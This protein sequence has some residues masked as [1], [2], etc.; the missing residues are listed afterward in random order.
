MATAARRSWSGFV[1]ERVQVHPA[2]LSELDLHRR[3]LVIIGG[4]GGIGR[5]IARAAASRGARV[6]VVGRTFR[7]EGRPG[8]SFVRAD[9]SSMKEARR[10]GAEL[11]V[12]LADTIVFTNGIMASRKRELTDEGLE[13][14]LATSFLS[15]LVVLRGLA[16]RLGTERPPGA[17]A[18]RVFVMGFPGAGQLGNLGNLMGERA[19]DPMDVHMNTVAGNEALVLDGKQ[20]YP[21]LHFFGLNPGMIKTNIRTHFMGSGF[22]HWLVEFVIGVLKQSPQAYAE[23]IVP[24]LFSP[25]LERQNGVMFGAKGQAILPTEG[26]E[27]A[28]TAALIRAS[29]ALVSKVVALPA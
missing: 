25:E 20:R 4:T 10:L 21:R 2:R 27:G 3:R 8:L 19:Y 23:R 13:R 15:R 5:A 16:P 1:D 26:L 18:P 9:L 29:E 12:E 17:P 6:A 14:D 7:D 22:A 24:V 28:R 11:P